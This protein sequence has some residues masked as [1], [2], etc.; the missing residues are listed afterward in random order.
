[1]ANPIHP[2][3]GPSNLGQHYFDMKF[4]QGGKDLPNEITQK[5]SKRPNKMRANKHSITPR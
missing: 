1:M 2:A 4:T 3:Q 5:A